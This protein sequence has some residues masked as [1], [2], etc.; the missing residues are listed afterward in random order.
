MKKLLALAVSM[1]TLSAFGNIY[2]GTFYFGTTLFGTNGVI[3]VSTNSNVYAGYQNFQSVTSVAYGN[4]GVGHQNFFNT[5]NMGGGNVGIGFENFFNTTYLTDGNVGL[6]FANFYNATNAMRGNF[7]AGYE[8]F[9]AATSIGRGNIVIGVRSESPYGTSPS[10]EL[11][12]GSV[13]FGTG[14]NTNTGV[15]SYSPPVGAKLGLN[16]TNLVTE[17]NVGGTLTV[18]SNVNYGGTI[19]GNGGGLTNLNGGMLTG[20]V[21]ATNLT[22]FT[23]FA[24]PVNTNWIMAYPGIGASGLWPSVTVLAG[25]NA[26]FAWPS[27]RIVNEAKLTGKNTL[28]ISADIGTTN[29]AVI[30]ISDSFI[31]ITSTT[32]YSY[33][34]FSATTTGFYGITNISGTVA[35][36]TNVLFDARGFY[37]FINNA[38]STNSFYVGQN[39]GLKLQ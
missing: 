26:R 2:T 24:Q 9:F 29:S 15:G 23:E 7:V 27:A 22:G 34:T 3:T 35:V 28:S 10:G 38:G 13:I 11:Q 19:T 20:P 18:Q 6:G 5:T 31:V 21:A 8:N 14:L 25:G 12:L 32:N 17:V 30:T 33:L 39:F 16:T 36:P 1:L 4:V 37:L